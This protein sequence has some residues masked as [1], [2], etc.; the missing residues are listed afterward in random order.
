MQDLKYGI[1]INSAGVRICR[2]CS[3]LVLQL[4]DQLVY[5]TEGMANALEP[6]LKAVTLTQEL[7]DALR[8]ANNRLKD[9][10]PKSQWAYKGCLEY[11]ALL[12]KAN[13]VGKVI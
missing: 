3:T 1:V 13:S 11:D 12:A 5:C 10:Y 4:G 8:R 7:A 2:D 6:R 9:E